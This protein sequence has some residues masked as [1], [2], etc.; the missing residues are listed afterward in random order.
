VSIKA[1]DEVALGYFTLIFFLTLTAFY[2]LKEGA[3]KF[4]G[5]NG[6]KV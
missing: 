3:G 4:L 2:S 6:H 1:V 5:G